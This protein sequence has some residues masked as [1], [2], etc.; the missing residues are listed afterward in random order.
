MS[1]L[2]LVGIVV[3][4]AEVRRSTLTDFLFCAAFAIIKQLKSKTDE[5]VAHVHSCFTCLLRFSFFK[6]LF[7][8]KRL[9]I[10]LGF[11]IK[12]VQ[13]FTTNVEMKRNYQRIFVSIV[14]RPVVSS[15]SETSRCCAQSQLFWT[16]QNSSD[17]NIVYLPL[18]K[19]QYQIHNC[20]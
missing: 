9:K 11:S 1:V 19:F 4:T 12:N 8:K 2:H 18:R 16:F 17:I 13:I 5:S 10:L 20:S 15:T 7:L 14:S 3:L 6:P